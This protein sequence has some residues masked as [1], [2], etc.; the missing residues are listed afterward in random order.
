MQVTL[1]HGKEDDTDIAN[2]GSCKANNI[3]E[4]KLP[5]FQCRFSSPFAIDTTNHRIA[6]KVYDLQCMRKD[7]HQIHQYIEK[8]YQDNPTIRFHMLRHHDFHAYCNAICCQN[9]Y[10]VN[11]SIIPLEQISANLMFYLTIHIKEIPGV[12]DIQTHKLTTSQGWYN[13]ITNRKWFTSV[14]EMI[15]NNLHGSI[16]EIQSKHDIDL[17]GLPTVNVK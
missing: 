9:M 15:Q 13:V 17:H 3:E 16:E 5:K 6:M 8:A 10:L 1:H 14:T 4:H 7:I 2:L 11:Q 12:Y